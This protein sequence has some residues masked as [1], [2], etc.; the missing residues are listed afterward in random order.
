VLDL[1]KPSCFDIVQA[2]VRHRRVGFSGGGRGDR[3]VAVG[4]GPVLLPE[5]ANPQDMQGGDI[6]GGSSDIHTVILCAVPTEYE[7][8]KAYFKP[9]EQLL[10]KGTIGYKS[11]FADYG[12]AIVVL[13]LQGMGNI[14]AAI[15]TQHA[16][17]VWRPEFL[18]LVGIAGGFPKA[19]RYLGDL[20]AADQLI[21]YELGKLSDKGVARRPQVFR[22]SPLLIA[23]AQSVAN[24]P[25]AW[26]DQ[27]KYP[28]PDGTSG[29]IN[30]TVHIG[31]V[32]SG[33]KVV[34]S[35]TFLSEFPDM[36]QGIVG[37]EMEGAGAGLAVYRSDTQPEFL[38]IKS[39]CDWA[40][41][42]KNDA[43]QQYAGHVSAAFARSILQIIW[44]KFGRPAAAEIPR[45][46]LQVECAGPDRFEICKR[47]Y[48]SRDDIA[49]YY[50]I[51]RQDRARFKPGREMTE[52]WEWLVDRDN[53][54][55]LPST[56]K[57]LQREDVIRD[58]RA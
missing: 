40:D 21:Y 5:I 39:I 50:E 44:T 17:D 14:S 15:E 54:D 36:W 31:S 7:A 16:I 29:R 32:L 4:R 52:V 49:D 2:M 12:P 55:S 58:F 43:W 56:L 35:E 41:P 26:L 24:Q 51:S 34:T 1:E 23:A 10:S 25:Y 45:R 47:L 53:L 28:R 20:I 38:M 8:L 6:S 3:E 33:D 19:D 22:A 48:G 13:L 11:R 37:I 18:L 42:S 27:I 46:T 57:R 30:P 9:E